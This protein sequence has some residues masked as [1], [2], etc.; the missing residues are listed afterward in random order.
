MIQAVT[1]VKS[2][3]PLEVAA[4]VASVLTNR[5]DDP[6]VSP[7]QRCPKHPVV[8]LI[9]QN[10]HQEN[11]SA[12]SSMPQMH[13]QQNPH[14]MRMFS[15]VFNP[16]MQPA[17]YPS[18][19]S[20]LHVSGQQCTNLAHIQNRSMAAPQCFVSPGCHKP[21]LNKPNPNANSSV[22]FMQRE[23]TCCRPRPQFTVRPKSCFAGGGVHSRSC[24]NSASTSANNMFLSLPPVQPPPLAHKPPITGPNVASNICRSDDDSAE[25]GTDL[26][27][28][29]SNAENSRPSSSRQQSIQNACSNRPA[30]CALP[31]ES[32][33]EQRSLGM[34]NGSGESKPS[35]AQSTSAINFA[36]ANTTDSHYAAVQSTSSSTNDNCFLSPHNLFTCFHHTPSDSNASSSLYQSIPYYRTK[37]CPPTNQNSIDNST[38]PQSMSLQTSQAM[39]GHSISGASSSHQ[40]PSNTPISCRQEA[41][42]RSKLGLMS[43]APPAA[44][45]GGSPDRNHARTQS[46]S[47][48]GSNPSSANQNRKHSPSSRGAGPHPSGSG[49]QYNLCNNKSANIGDTS[50]SECYLSGDEAAGGAVVIANPEIR[51]RQVRFLP[52]A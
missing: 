37:S 35:E 48:G 6:V 19:P 34:D 23:E 22:A 30:S 2:G 14:D 45:F 11:S 31:V 33:T 13:S 7:M 27:C 1:S 10:R 46:W 47:V 51:R 12:N 15:N 49:S 52:S 18:F 38:T 26:Q 16:N 42:V 50:D 40:Q 3:K 28:S 4:A 44:A 8:P 41:A 36:N 5:S 20:H 43:L 32:N 39:S 9:P 24:S 25:S 17:N 21:T 29:S